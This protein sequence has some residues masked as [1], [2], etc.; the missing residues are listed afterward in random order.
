M[1]YEPLPVAS[2]WQVN[3]TLRM[4]PDAAGGADGVAL[5]VHADPRGPAAVG[6][7]GSSLGVSW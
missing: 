1:W 3:V 4:A 7:D 5:V 2:A 6:S